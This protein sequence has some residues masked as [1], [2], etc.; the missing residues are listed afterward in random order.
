MNGIVIEGNGSMDVNQALEIKNALL[1]L[2]K[3]LDI[4][5]SVIASNVCFM[6]KEK[7]NILKEASDKWS[8]FENA[9][10]VERGEML[11]INL[12]LTKA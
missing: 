1:V 3:T 2:S 4:K 10:I 7:F 12:H 5:F 6:D 11:G 8:E 9:D